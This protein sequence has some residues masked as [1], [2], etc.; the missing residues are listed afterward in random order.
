MGANRTE[1][2]NL[3][4]N[5]SSKNLKNKV[6]ESKIGNAYQKYLG[7]MALPGA[8]APIGGMMGSNMLQEKADALAAS[9]DVLGSQDFN[10]YADI[11]LGAGSALGA[12][13]APL[14][15]RN[16]TKQ[17]VS[18]ALDMNERSRALQKGKRMSVS[19]KADTALNAGTA[20]QKAG[21]GIVGTAYG[22]N[23]LNIAM[24]GNS[25]VPGNALIGVSK[26]AGAGTLGTGA[27]NGYTIAHGGNPLAS[28]NGGPMDFG[29]AF[30]GSTGMA[31]AA[32]MFSGI[33][34][35]KITK[36]IK[37]MAS[38]STKDKYKYRSP[39]LNAPS[40]DRD[41]DKYNILGTSFGAQVNL[42]MMTDKLSPYENLVLTALSA[43]AKNTGAGPALYQFLTGKEDLGSKKLKLAHNKMAA[44][45]GQEDE[46]SSLSGHT[47]AGKKGTI[48]QIVQRYNDI[49]E[50]VD[51][52]IL[53]V[54]KGIQG[55]ATALNPL[56]ILFGGLFGPSA[57]KQITSLFGLD[58][59]SIR[60]NAIERT[61]K[62]LNLPVSMVTIAET[63]A[64][65]ILKMAGDDP[66]SKKI[67][68]LQLIAEI[69]RNQ[70]LLMLDEKKKS[71]GGFIGKTQEQFELMDTSSGVT[72]ALKKFRGLV[73][74]V[75][76]IGLIAS[77]LALQEARERSKEDTAR[78][79]MDDLEYQKGISN[80]SLSHESLANSFLGTEFPSLF[81]NS[82]N[83]DVERNLLLSEIRNRLDHE[84][85]IK[86][87]TNFRPMHIKRK[88]S[89]TAWDLVTGSIM[90]EQDARNS[91]QSAF[92]K[93]EKEIIEFFDQAMKK[94]PGEKK[95]IK[96]RKE[97]ELKSLRDKYKIDE[98][99]L[100]EGK[101]K[102][103]KEKRE[104]LLTTVLVKLEKYLRKSDKSSIFGA[105]V[106]AGNVGN[107][108]STRS[109]LLGLFGKLKNAYIKGGV[110][111]VVFTVLQ[112]V[113]KS[114]AVLLKWAWKNKIGKIL[115]GLAI[116]YLG[117]IAYT[118]S[119]F[120]RGFVD[121][122]IKTILNMSNTSTAL[123]AGGTVIAYTG[124][125]KLL[126]TSDARTLFRIGKI[127][128]KRAKNQ[129]MKLGAAVLLTGLIGGAMLNQYTSKGKG[130]L[131]RLSNSLGFGG[132]VED[133]EKLRT[134]DTVSMALGLIGWSLI[135]YAKNPYVK[136]AGA[137]MVLGSLVMTTDW[138]D[139]INK[140]KG[141][142]YDMLGD[143]I[144]P[145]EW[146]K[147]SSANKTESGYAKGSHKDNVYQLNKLHKE[148]S[149]LE[150][151]RMM[152][153]KA[154]ERKLIQE[155]AI[156]IINKLSDEARSKAEKLLKLADT[157]NSG[158]IS[159]QESED[160]QLRD[161]FIKMAI[162]QNKILNKIE[163]KTSAQWL[164]A[165]EDRKVLFDLANAVYRSQNKTDIDLTII[166]AVKNGKIKYERKNK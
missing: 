156:S 79:L 61:A 88:A 65:K 126:K 7:K 151:K 112:G 66:D 58:E 78:K 166:S 114:I 144:V 28:L 145:D 141:I 29:D 27:F 125:M 142:L 74:N 131:G 67:A 44:L 94:H 92:K 37:N 73:G 40:P 137:T 150:W 68:V 35:G 77:I 158:T 108:V 155:G 113:G 32:L 57:E 149:D 91:K 134:T 72:G 99:S 45:M 41:L 161:E 101:D 140:G 81:L 63:R 130:L 93:N 120:I 51:K 12:I 100:Q 152:E 39:A 49:M 87:P 109:G 54:S 80:D 9:G 127:V 69:N 89:N 82:L 116:G 115:P 146:A 56:N 163:D 71:D 84:A 46:F 90:T 105:D 157:D 75:P 10:N 26:V 119:N 19:Q 33:L 110:T 160:V 95:Q 122:G 16:A 11:A 121:G 165:S 13:A 36:S 25:L 22:A 96:K 17:N 147:Y 42:L 118:K 21:M 85:Y 148:Q 133:S 111:G 14:M 3:L 53:G 128:L 162:E 106:K 129:K 55:G 123:L 1:Y 24:G 6:D 4:R 70:L 139:S 153:R 8:L 34:G 104:K 18:N 43:I 103:N 164:S 20:I 62:N 86:N 143:T 60:D 117:Y 50:S 47:R 83:L 154:A 38:T 15:F 136:I 48:E 97:E 124:V 159:T 5:D 98:L 23:A 31:M 138:T 102:E 30:G 59:E 2:E 132:E 76:G 107:V 135:K 64:D 52:T